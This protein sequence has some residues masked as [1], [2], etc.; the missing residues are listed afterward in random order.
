MGDGARYICEEDLAATVWAMRE[1]CYP[2]WAPSEVLI[3]RR[4]P[5]DAG[6]YRRFFRAPTRFN[7]ETAAVV[8]PAGL[9]SWR[10]P[11]ANPAV[12]TALEQRII[13]LE[14]AAP[15][16]LVDEMRRLVRTE[17]SKRRSMAQEVTERFFMNRRTLA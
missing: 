15:P 10:L 2:D 11:G 13:E 16:D 14:R 3:P 8:F 9:L 6:P 1:L 4:E 12:L 7:E 5:A 17:L